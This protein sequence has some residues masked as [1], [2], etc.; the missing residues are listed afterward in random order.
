[1]H[2]L[3]FFNNSI[4]CSIFPLH[5]R[6]H[7]SRFACVALCR[8]YSTNSP[9]VPIKIYSNADLQKLLIIQENKAKPG[10]YRWINLTNNQSYVGS[11]VNLAKREYFNI[12]FLEREIKKNKSIIYRS[13]IKY[14]YSNF[15]LEILEYCDRSEAVIREQYYLYLL[16][17]NYNLLKTAGSVLGYKHLP[18]SKTR[19][20]TPERKAKR[21][22]YLNL[23]NSSKEQQDQLKRLQA[24]FKGRA[25]PEGSGVPSITIEVLDRE[26]GIKTIYPSISEAAQAIGVT[27]ASISMAFKRLQGAVVTTEGG[28]SAILIKKRYMITKLSK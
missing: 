20:W 27:R 22:E 28:A 4:F 26:T 7:C 2:Q 10:V 9:V 24:S 16:K 13:L 11:S 1:M 21:L 18:D 8:T 19:I 5:F 23:H 12:N 6:F 25:R 17:P 14:G 3:L 15:S